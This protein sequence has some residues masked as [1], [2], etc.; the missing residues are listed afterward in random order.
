[1]KR[2]N[3]DCKTAVIDYDEL[4]IEDG[5][6][7]FQDDP[8]LEHESSRINDYD[9]S[10]LHYDH[11]KFNE[12]L[13]RIN[14]KRNDAEE[15]R[16]K[17][18][19]LSTSKLTDTFSDLQ[20]LFNEGTAAF[21]LLHGEFQA[22]SNL[23]EHKIQKAGKNFGKINYK[24][25]WSEYLCQVH[26][27]ALQDFLPFSFS[28]SEHKH[29]EYTF[30]W[31]YTLGKQTFDKGKLYK[32]ARVVMAKELPGHKR[33]AMTFK[34]SKKILTGSWANVQGRQT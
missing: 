28:E 34:L 27:I 12:H 23:T 18:I 4:K 30:T 2:I 17:E 21:E 14:K 29:S 32:A 19:E 20:K 16:K 10:R 9:V 15:R 33:I 3:P 1:M 25:D 13:A 26:T 8:D 6:D 24:Q 5:G 7:E 31:F 11:E 22:V